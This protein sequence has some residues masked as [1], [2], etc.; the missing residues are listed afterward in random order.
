MLHSP[1]VLL[2]PVNWAR[3]CDYDKRDMCRLQAKEFTDDMNSPG[4]PLAATIMGVL[5]ETEMP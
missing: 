3:P 4:P 5:V 2:F 1:S